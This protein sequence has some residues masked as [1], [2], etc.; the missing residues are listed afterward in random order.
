MMR[1]AAETDALLPM[2]AYQRQNYL[3]PY[4]ANAST[5]F[6]QGAQFTQGSRSRGS[7]ACVYM[8]M[9]VCLYTMT[10]QIAARTPSLAM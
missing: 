2:A 1:A 10:R 9:C 5:V 6:A 8:Y 4:A 3:F 7:I